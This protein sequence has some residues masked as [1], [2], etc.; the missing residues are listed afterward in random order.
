MPCFKSYNYT[1]I[2]L[3]KPVN[4]QPPD[5]SKSQSYLRRHLTAFLHHLASSVSSQTPSPWVSVPDRCTHRGATFRHLQFATALGEWSLSPRWL[6]TTPII[7]TL[8]LSWN[9]IAIHV[10]HFPNTRLILISNLQPSF[11]P[12]RTP[13]P[14]L[15]SIHYRKPL[16]HLSEFHT[17]SVPHHK[18]CRFKL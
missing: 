15:H 4:A 16:P 7:H 1:S 14:V 13:P 10:V 18:N 2:F 3:S 11:P 17:I 8:T 6:I 12:W 9:V 5:L